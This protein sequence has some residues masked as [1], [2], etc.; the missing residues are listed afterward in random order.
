[1]NCW[2]VTERAGERQEYKGE[3][4]KRGWQRETVNQKFRADRGGREEVAECRE[5]GSSKGQ[6][7]AAV[8]L[9]VAASFP[10]S[11]A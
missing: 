11:T 1:M 4:K 2:C 8:L 10:F 9:T 7:R 3:E 6:L 5:K